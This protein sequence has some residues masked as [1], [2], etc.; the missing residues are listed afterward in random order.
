[1]DDLGPEIAVFLMDTELRMKDK[2]VPMFEKALA[3]R[4]QEPPAVLRLER[5]LFAAGD[6][7]FIVNAKESIA[8]NIGA[9][10]SRYFRGRGAEA[11][12]TASSPRKAGPSRIGPELR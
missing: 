9:V 3:A 6:R 7:I 10:V 5:E 12:R 11:Q 2:L 8:G 1:V 4:G